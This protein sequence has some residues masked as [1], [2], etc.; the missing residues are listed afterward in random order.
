MTG[1]VLA[2]VGWTAAGYL[3]GSVN[4]AILIT[5]IVTGR[6]I[7]EMG[8]GNPGTANVARCVGKGWAAIV[9]I[10]DSAKGFLPLLAASRLSF[11]E[12]GPAGR[13]LLTIVGIAAILGHCRPLFHRFRGGG[14]LATATGVFVFFVLLELCAAA[15]MALVL[16]GVFFRDRRYPLGRWVPMIYGMLTPFLTLAAAFIP[17]YNRDG[18]FRIG[19]NP[20]HTVLGAFAVTIAVIFLNGSELIRTFGTG[21]SG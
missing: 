12:N 21:D 19:G 4:H 2:A 9:F 14:G 15:L 3:A 7:R 18:W 13:L 17:P 8:N 20:W 10:G 16:V 6:D 1:I 5:R 11:T